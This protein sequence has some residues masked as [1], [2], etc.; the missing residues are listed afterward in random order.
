MFL[1]TLSST[2]SRALPRYGDV[3]SYLKSR[4]VT[5]QDITKYELGFLK[6]ISVPEDGSKNRDRFMD[7]SWRGRKF[8]SKLI[9]PIKDPIGRVIGIIGRSITSKA[10]AT[11]VLDE[12]KFSGFLFG[13][14]QALPEIYKTNRVYVVEG[15]FD[16]P[17]LSKVLPN[18]VGSL[19]SG[20]Y[21]NQ[22]E[23]LKFFCENIITVFDTDEPG[24]EGAEKA[25]KWALWNTR[26]EEVPEWLINKKSGVKNIVL[27]YKD[28]DKALSDLGMKKFRELITKKVKELSLF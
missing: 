21:K 9:F 8:E 10:F 23:I 6:I 15:V 25:G 20:L 13:L 5:G 17:A 7:E 26:K 16:T 12:A 27:G 2:A 11:F 18:T 4:N 22:Y 14:Y 19:S 24:Q 1:D 3:L 28:P